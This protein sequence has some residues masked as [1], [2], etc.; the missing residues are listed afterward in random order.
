MVSCLNIRTNKLSPPVCKVMLH[1]CRIASMAGRGSPTL[2]GD[3]RMDVVGL[4]RRHCE[5]DSYSKR[6]K[7]RGAFLTVDIHNMSFRGLEHATEPLDDVIPR[8]F[9]K[10][11]LGVLRENKCDAATTQFCINLRHPGIREANGVFYPFRTHK[12]LN[13]VALTTTYI[14]ARYHSGGDSK[15]QSD[16]ADD[17]QSHGR[18]KVQQFDLQGHIPPDASPARSTT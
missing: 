18:S 17:V 5:L 6:I 14:G 11:I 16:N 12:V 8:L 9:D 7:H 3:Q 2:V 10:F 1:C 15:R 4:W 13:G